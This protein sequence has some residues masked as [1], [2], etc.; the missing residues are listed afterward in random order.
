M[1][2]SNDCSHSNDLNDYLIQKEVVFKENIMEV[3]T[4]EYRHLRLPAVLD[5][6]S[7]PKLL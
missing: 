2:R 4:F 3:K 1:Q 7:D 5:N 6:S